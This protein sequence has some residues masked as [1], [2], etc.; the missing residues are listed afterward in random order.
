M[1]NV[2]SSSS[3]DEGIPII[4]GHMTKR[5]PI[6]RSELYTSTHAHLMQIGCC[7]GFFLYGCF[8]LSAQT[9]TFCVCLCAPHPH[10]L[11]VWSTDA[12]D[13]VLPASLAKG[14]VS[15]CDI[16]LLYRNV[17]TSPGWM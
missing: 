2:L 14:Q 12:S 16:V 5:G 8:S 4:P 11:I 15:C 10:P 3:R 1:Y 9:H 7:D 6:D 13:A 17:T